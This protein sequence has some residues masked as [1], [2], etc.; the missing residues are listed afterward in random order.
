MPRSLRRRFWIETSL[1]A[2]TGVLAIV[3]VLWHDWIEAI[4]G[5]NPDNGSGSAEWRTVTVLVIISVATAIGAR[6]EWRHARL[7]EH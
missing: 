3:T 2:A 5:V 1:A 7:E 4:F 6:L